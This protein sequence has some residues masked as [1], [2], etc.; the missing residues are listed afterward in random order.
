MKLLLFLLSLILPSFADGYIRNV[1][2][3]DWSTA[4]TIAV[5]ENFRRLDAQSSRTTVKGYSRIKVG[6]FTSSASTGNQS[7]SG[8][9]FSPRFVFFFVGVGNSSTLTFGLGVMTASDQWAWGAHSTDTDSGGAA[10]LSTSACLIRANTAGTTLL[11]GSFVSMDSDGFTVNWTTAE[12][13]T[14]GYVAFQ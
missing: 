9:G 3:N 6:T 14:V 7:V 11:E 2:G 1:P 10:A 12:A 4:D 8:V 13:R 5:N